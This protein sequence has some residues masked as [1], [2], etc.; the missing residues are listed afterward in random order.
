MKEFEG[1]IRVE[2]CPRTYT[3]VATEELLSDAVTAHHY[4]VGL[5]DAM[6]KKIVLGEEMTYHDWQSSNTCH[7]VYVL[8]KRTVMSPP[9]DWPKNTPCPAD[10]LVE[11]VKPYWRHESTHDTEADAM[12][13]VG[14]LLSS[15]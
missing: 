6:G 3:K 8:D 1:K 13:Q 7:K 12:V 5:P 9:P 11:K 2:E 10:Q 15:Q 14:K 4:Q